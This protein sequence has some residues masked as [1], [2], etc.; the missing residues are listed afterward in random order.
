MYTTGKLL[1]TTIAC[2]CMI[3]AM[4]ASGNPQANPAGPSP[5]PAP[6]ATGADSGIPD[7]I[8]DTPLLAPE[9]LEAFY[10]N[11]NDRS[12]WTRQNHWQ[13]LVDAIDDAGDDGLNP[14]DYHWELLS[15]I[16]YLNVDKLPQDLREDLDL[17]LSDAFLVFASHLKGGKINPGTLDPEWHLTRH[18]QELTELME[19]ALASGRIRQALDSLRPAHPAYTRL[20]RARRDIVE[21]MDEPWDRLPDGPSI[22]PGD[23]DP[24]LPGIQQRLLLLGDLPVSGAPAQ[25]PPASLPVYG[26]PLVTAVPPVPGPP[27]TGT[28]MAL[29]VRTPWK[30]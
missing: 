27:W 20:V 16:Q 15:E 10:R 22:R 17:L 1:H 18:R 23:T 8:L 12:A 19:T 6:P 11:R 2:A 26:G 29:S 24:R 30:P 7:R 14:A 3:L 9:A 13:Q 28:R 25:A 21:K 5:E 4:A